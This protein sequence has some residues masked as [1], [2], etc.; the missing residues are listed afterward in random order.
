MNRDNPPRKAIPFPIGEVRWAHEAGESA[1]G[2]RYG[3]YTIQISWARAASAR[4]TTGPG[5]RAGD[6]IYHC[7]VKPSN[8]LI[9]TDGQ[10]Y[11]SDFGLALA[12]ENPFDHPDRQKT[13]E[14]VR[15]ARVVPLRQQHPEIPEELDR[16]CLRALSRLA[17]DRFLPSADFTE[18][19]R[20]ASHQKVLRRLGRIV[21][22]RY[23]LRLGPERITLY[24]LLSPPK[25]LSRTTGIAP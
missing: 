12:G 21:R 1:D 10:P 2:Q 3:A 6:E 15:G 7:D 17:A 23:H 19:P 13:L 9:G 4:C 24:L 14:L 20:A 18:Q 16:I 11:L 5:T 8:I 25:T 22:R